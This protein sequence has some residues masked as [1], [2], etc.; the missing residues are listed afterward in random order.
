M[1]RIRQ[2]GCDGAVAV[3]VSNPRRIIDA[4]H[5]LW[6]LDACHYPW[7]E[8][9]GVV[10]FFGDPTPIQRNYLAD[11]LRHDAS[12]YHLDGSVHVQV[13][14]ADGDEVRESSWLDQAA[15]TSGLPTA[16]VAF[17]DLAA[18]NAQ[19]MLDQQQ[20]I[21]RVRGIRHIVGRSSAE[22]A[23]TGSDS[24][25]KNPMWIENLASLRERNLSFD[26]QLI[27]TQVDKVA[28][29]LETVPGLR[30]A[31]CHCGSPWDQ[32]V[33]GFASW[34]TGLRRLA[35]NPD[36]YCKISGLSMFHHDWSVDDLRPVVE[37]CIEIF[38]A[39][40][41]MFGSNF[42]VDKLHKTWNEVWSAYESI[43][44]SCSAREQDRLFAGTAAEF[45]RIS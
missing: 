12:D 37:S 38:G 15:R 36:V 44:A 45:Y 1:D 10:R 29:I 26:L 11:E 3:T 13:G 6:D 24:L 2:P 34:R 35:G 16:L 27:P 9:K 39:D 30:V 7:L 18:G 33:A 31:L 25:L 28:A 42:P 32:T 14:V 8:E 4:H 17:C 21:G 5:H 40:R 43:S 23:N 22:D 19:K 20:A 41:C